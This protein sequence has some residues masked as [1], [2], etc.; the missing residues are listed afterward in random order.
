MNSHPRSRTARLNW[1]VRATFWCA[2]IGFAIGAQSLAV[3]LGV[4]V[5]VSLAWMGKDIR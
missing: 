2:V 3:W 1:L 4:A 5:L